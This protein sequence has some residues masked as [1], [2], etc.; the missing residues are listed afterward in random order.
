MSSEHR[1]DGKTH[2]LLTLTAREALEPDQTIVFEC[3]GGGHCE[4]AMSEFAEGYVPRSAVLRVYRTNGQHRVVMHSGSIVHFRSRLARPLLERV[5]VQ[6]QDD[7]SPD[8]PPRHKYKG[9][10]VFR[11]VRSKDEDDA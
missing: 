4:C 10:R 11:A 6:A 3:Y 2:A 8:D 5:D 9:A 7:W 1:Q